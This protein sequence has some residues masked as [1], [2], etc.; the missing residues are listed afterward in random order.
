M[1][2]ITAVQL[3]PGR[4]GGIEARLAQDIDAKFQV[5]CD[6]LQ[7]INGE[8][9]VSS[10]ETCN[11]SLFERLHCTLCIVCAMVSW[12]HKLHLDALALKIFAEAF[13]EDVV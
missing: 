7:G 3:L 12:W 9:R 4:N 11:E 5:R 2:I 6:E 1:V 13:V 8:V 10:R